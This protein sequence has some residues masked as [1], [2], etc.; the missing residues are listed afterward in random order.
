[1]RK[2]NAVESNT[3]SLGRC[4]APLQT[5]GG[6]LHATSF[7]LSIIAPWVGVLLVALKFLGPVGFSAEQLS[8]LTEGGKF[9]VHQ[10][11]DVPIYILAI[12]A[13]TAGIFC[14]PWRKCLAAR[15]RPAVL[16]LGVLGLL[17]SI[18]PAINWT[19]VNQFA[20]NL[21]HNTTFPLLYGILAGTVS[22]PALIL[23]LRAPAAETLSAEI[24][25]LQIPR[26]SFVDALFLLFLF[27]LI[28]IPGST[29]L[30]ARFFQ[31][32]EL[33][34]WNG[35]VMAAAAS[36]KHGG[37]LY[38]DF[39]P[40]YGAFWPCLYGWISQFTGLYYSHAITFAMVFSVFY[41]GGVYYLLRHFSLSRGAAAGLTLVGVV[42]AVFPGVE[43][44]TKSIIWRWNGGFLLRAPSDLGFLLALTRFCVKPSRGI[45]IAMGVCVGLG[46]LFTVDVGLFLLSTF[47]VTWTLLLLSTRTRANLIFFALS[48]GSVIPTVVLGLSA[49]TRGSLFEQQTFQSIWNYMQRTASG[50]GLIPFA[51]VDQKCVC[52]FA[53]QCLV[54]LGLLALASRR[55]FGKHSP[56]DALLFALALFPL[57]RTVYFMGRSHWANLA[58]IFVTTLI[59]ISI[60]LKATILRDVR[61][62]EPHPIQARLGSSREHFLSVASFIFAACL[63][64]TSRD[65]AH[66]PALWNPSAR[67][68]IR[69]GTVTV[70]HPDVDLAGLPAPYQGYAQAY[71]IVGQRMNELHKKGLHVRYLD[72]CSTTLYVFSD[73]P[74]FG[75]D[76][77]EFDRADSSKAAIRELVQ[78]LNPT[79][80]DI[81]VLN[82]AQFPYPRILSMEAWKAC[83]E[84]LFDHYRKKEEIGPFEVWWRQN[85]STQ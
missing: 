61:S 36:V 25:Q 38:R 50:F 68:E 80:P 14:I 27:F 84:R 23:L 16:T 58:A 83:R 73:I 35:F 11:K 8:D 34:H 24:V 48:A 79:G 52:F 47:V 37:A 7:F 74:P 44:E 67:T 2:N 5:G 17:L 33:N 78:E 69:T 72:A 3:A 19:P 1:M 9:W 85:A 76:T 20:P 32:D 57:Q 43:P 55:P 18:W 45:S 6:W 56:T 10:E 49:A 22:L 39:I 70:Q 53:L 51:F 81:V 60:F 65:I 15:P 12:A 64:F 26:L 75:K 42:V 31:I 30:A 46:L 29:Y 21:E 28:F 66:Y 63:F 13:L 54:L 41:L 62:P 77:H 4:Q 59:S 40:I 82:K 71:N